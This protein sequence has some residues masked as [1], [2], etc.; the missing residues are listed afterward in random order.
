MELNAGTDTMQTMKRFLLAVAILSSAG[1][2][3]QETQAEREAAFKAGQQAGRVRRD[4]VVFL[5]ALA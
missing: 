3:A 1:V 2:A 5:E 4:P